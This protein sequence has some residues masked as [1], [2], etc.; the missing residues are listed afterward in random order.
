MI[1]YC[2]MC[3]SRL[4]QKDGMVDY[5]CENIHCPARKIESLIHFVSRN[6]MNIDGLGDRIIEDFYH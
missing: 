1:D 4:I 6:A 3:G 5:F 2:P